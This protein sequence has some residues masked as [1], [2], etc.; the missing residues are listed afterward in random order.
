M[1]DSFENVIRSRSQRTRKMRAARRSV[2]FTDACD[3]A[4]KRLQLMLLGEYWRFMS[5]RKVVRNRFTVFSVAKVP[6]MT[7]LTQLHL[8]LLPLP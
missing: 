1:E 7:W 5:C 3:M 6:L 2:T 8:H 4:R